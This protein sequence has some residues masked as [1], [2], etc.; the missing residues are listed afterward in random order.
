M[1]TTQVEKNRHAKGPTTDISVHPPK[2]YVA[3]KNSIP[4]PLLKSTNLD[5]ARIW[6]MLHPWN[7]NPRVF[8]RR[9]LDSRSPWCTWRHPW[10]GIDK[11]SI[12]WDRWVGYLVGIPLSEKVWGIVVSLWRSLG[13]VDEGVFKLVVE[14]ALNVGRVG[15]RF[16]TISI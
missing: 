6:W 2:I 10:W 3:S 12:I 13:I 11:H 15:C 9:P 16:Q 7:L 4:N 8:W 5:T 1:Y 14:G